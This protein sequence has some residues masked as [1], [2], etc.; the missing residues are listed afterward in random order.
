MSTGFSHTFSQPLESKIRVFSWESP[1]YLNT[2]KSPIFRSWALTY[3]AQPDWRTTLPEFL[4]T[5]TS[6]VRPLRVSSL[7]DFGILPPKLCRNSFG[8]VCNNIVNRALR[9]TEAD[10]TSSRVTLPKS[11]V[12]LIWYY[13]HF[14]IYDTVNFLHHIFKICTKL[15]E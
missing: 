7:I 5:W 1:L 11:R 9:G 13:L 6:K 10:E 15:F 4:V 8:I 2:K 14:L 12:C 3:D